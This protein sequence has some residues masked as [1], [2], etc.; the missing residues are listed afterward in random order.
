[1][2]GGEPGCVSPK[3]DLIHDMGDV[4]HMLPNAIGAD[5]TTSIAE[6]KDLVENRI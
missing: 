6:V 4:S 5:L 3:D 2:I 1:M